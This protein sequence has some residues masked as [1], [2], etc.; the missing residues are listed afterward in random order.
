MRDD[1]RCVLR[2]AALG[3]V[4]GG[5]AGLLYSRLPGTRR[6]GES[7]VGRGGRRLDKGRLL[8]LGWSLIGFVRQVLSLG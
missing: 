5:V 1:L 8:R 7:G 4:L 2:G 3:A 6:S